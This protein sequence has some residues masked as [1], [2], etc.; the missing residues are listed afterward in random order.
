MD[1]DFLHAIDDGGHH[2]FQ[3]VSERGKHI[4]NGMLSLTYE[5]WFA[6]I[7][8]FRNQPDFNFKDVDSSELPP[9]NWE[10]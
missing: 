6:H 3:G 8:K 7:E 1:I 4:H 9:K 10:L 5:G 2:L